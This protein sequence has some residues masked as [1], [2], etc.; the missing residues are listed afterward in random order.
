[1]S[2]QEK[3]NADSNTSK[4]NDSSRRTSTLGRVMRYIRRYQIFVVISILCAAVTVALTL[5]VPILTGDAIDYIIE[6][7]LVDFDPV[8]SIVKQIVIVV[9]CTALAQWLMNV[10]NNRIAYHV[11]HDIRRD[12]KSVV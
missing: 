10:C 11:I 2:G 6:K 8:L 5:Y 4:Q 12:R 9:L 7:G 1:M 3:K